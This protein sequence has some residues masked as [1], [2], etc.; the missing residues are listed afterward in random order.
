LDGLALSKSWSAYNA[1]WQFAVYKKFDFKGYQ[2]DLDRKWAVL[3]RHGRRTDL[4][5]Q[6]G[7]ADLGEFNRAIIQLGQIIE[8]E[9]AETSVKEQT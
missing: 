7:A 8:E 6:G 9:T 1:V 5:A 4:L 2:G 3:A